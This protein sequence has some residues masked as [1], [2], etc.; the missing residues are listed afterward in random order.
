MDKMLK[1]G[2][3]MRAKISCHAFFLFMLCMVFCLFAS[4]CG[5][6]DDDDSDSNAPVVNDDADDDTQDLVDDDVNDDI[7]D[8]ADDDVDDDLDDD[9]D[10]DEPWPYS[11]PSES[12]PYE[13]GV[14]TRF[15]V[16]ENRYEVWGLSPRVL[17][18]EIWYPSNG[19]GGAP[20]EMPDIIG[21][22]PDWAMPIFEGVYGEEGAADL[23]AITTA[24][25]RGAEIT[26]RI[27]KFP[28]IIFSHGH[29]AIRFQN[30]TLCE[31]LASHGFIVVAPDHYG[32]AIFINSPQTGVV[33]INPL[34]IVTAYLE[35]P[36]DIDFVVG[37][38]AAMNIDEADRF[39]G[40]FDMEKLGL[41]GHSYGGL[42][43]L[44]GARRLDHFKAFAP[45]NPAWVGFFPKS[46]DKPM[47]ILQSDEDNI[48]GDAMNDGIKYIFENIA[49]PQKARILLYNAGHYSATN[50]CSLMP[51][52]LLG[53]SVGCDGQMVDT[54]VA[55]QLTSEY[56]TAFFLNILNDDPRYD[57][58]LRENHFPDYIDYTSTWDDANYAN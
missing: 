34:S 26:D 2:K 5:D 27:E 16:D 35:R 24:A 53:P 54:G 22:L 14:E 49:S 52:M 58:F 9:A 10:D 7:D 36:V 31:Y 15:F 29:M 44:L 30:Y 56:L 13:V 50:A 43:T 6:D 28:I 51:A 11:D 45:I 33:L 38:L 48:I 19:V 42:T 55:N 46:F 57:D 25:F 12:G 4:S 41:S 37:R 17:P 3:N 18:A 21:E 47:M 39:Y 20:N 1:T 32:N 8:D 23:M 40:R